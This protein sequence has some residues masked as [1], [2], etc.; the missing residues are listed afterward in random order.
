MR[1][2]LTPEGR[3]ACTSKRRNFPLF[4]GSS[5]ASTGLNFSAH[6]TAMLRELAIP[7]NP[8]RLL[9]LG[10]KVETKGGVSSRCN[11]KTQG[12]PWDKCP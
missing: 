5:T 11:L 8:A 7:A 4:A 1:A 10:N 12:F 3:S 6:L 2:K 9:H